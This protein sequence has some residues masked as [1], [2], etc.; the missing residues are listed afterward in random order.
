[1]LDRLAEFF[2]FGFVPLIAGALVMP[3][4]SM[5]EDKVVTGQ[6]L[7]R[8]PITLPPNAVLTVQLIEE[9][10]AGEP[11]AIIGQQVV[12]N[13][14]PAPIRFEVHFDP[15]AIRP[16]ATYVLEANI[17]VGHALWFEN[18]SRYELDPLTAGPQ[19]L[20]LEMLKKSG[21]EN[22]SKSR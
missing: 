19:T 7:Y 11:T 21:D 1:M 20:V 9:S 18:D 8:E 6:V 13:P 22:A 4:Q 14:G 12:P 17:S 3:T 15:L 2:I 10:P 16:E 5:A